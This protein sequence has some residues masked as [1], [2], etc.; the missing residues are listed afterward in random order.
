MPFKTKAPTVPGP[1]RGGPA[2]VES[3]ESSG[4]LSASSAVVETLALTWQAALLMAQLQQ[5]NLTAPA[6]AIVHASGRS[7]HNK[8]NMDPVSIALTLLMK[9]PS[10][11]VSAAEKVTA[12]VAVDV[13]RMRES[14]ADLSTGILKCY[15][16]T[17]HYQVSD[18]V[19]R[20]WPRQAQYAADN[21]AVI[22]I[23]YT[24]LTGTPYEMV[25]AVMVRS[26]QVRTAV[27]ADTALV[28][29]NKKCRLEQW[30]GA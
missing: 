21:S 17:A 9:N 11:A 18:I 27:L 8:G 16:K 22:R 23:R 25:V 20:P 29:F 14:F 7:Q 24:G 19:Q 3:P 5:R 15:H 4:R 26:D 10:A 12:P 30:S 6:A 13:G 1:Q 2:G 28:P